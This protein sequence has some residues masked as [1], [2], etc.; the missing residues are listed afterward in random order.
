[1][2]RG[3]SCKLAIAAGI[4]DPTN[5]I[6]TDP[7]KVMDAILSV[8]DTDAILVLMDMGSALLSAETALD[9]LEPEVAARVHLCD[10]KIAITR[11]QLA[12]SSISWT[13]VSQKQLVL[14]H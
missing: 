9:L 6:G 2:L 1:M 12:C 14:T 7:I 4:D 5:P 11:S 13:G 10:G 8:A 3:D